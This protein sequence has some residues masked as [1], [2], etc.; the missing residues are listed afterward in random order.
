M[1]SSPMRPRVSKGARPSFK[2]AS[3]HPHPFPASAIGCS[4]MQAT[5]RRC[6]GVGV[7][8]EKIKNSPEYN[9]LVLARE[10]YQVVPALYY[11]QPFLAF[12]AFHHRSPI[13]IESGAPC[14]R[15]RWFGRPATLASTRSSIFLAVTDSLPCFFSHRSKQEAGA[16]GRQDERK[17]KIYMDFRRKMG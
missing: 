13:H 5:F 10:E 3:G 6:V 12:L 7:S 17:A 9:P 4:R 8:R 15:V 11:V 1:T 14:H 2:A 16:L